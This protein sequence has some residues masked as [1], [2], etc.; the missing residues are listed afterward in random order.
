MKRTL[1][2]VDDHETVRAALRDWLAEVFHD[3]RILEAGTG[4]DAVALASS[5]A[6]DAVVMDVRLPG[7]NGIEAMR[8][9]KAAAP[10]TEVLILTV[11]DAA[12]YHTDAMASGAR[13]YVLKNRLH[14]DLVPELRKL[15]D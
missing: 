11:Y 6:I 9:V 8:R 13:A 5:E 12:D 14:K 7:I 2:I 15:L 4:E 3:I 1:L 10:D